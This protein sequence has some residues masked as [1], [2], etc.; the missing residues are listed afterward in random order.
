MPVLLVRHAHALARSDWD[1]DDDE[2]TLSVKGSQQARALV[3][4]LSGFAPTLIRSSPSVRCLD[5]VR[6]LAESTGVELAVEKRLAEGSGASAADLVRELTAGA[7][8]LCSHGDVI[9]DVLA[10]ISRVD[11]LGLDRQPRSEKG[12]VW[13][14]EGDGTRVTTARYIRPP[15]LD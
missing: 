2:R 10:A 15:K 9:P 6:P 1:G 3:A 4:I 12:S 8:V 11:E 5:T 7:A 14:L 13:I